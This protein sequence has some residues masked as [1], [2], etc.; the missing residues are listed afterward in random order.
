MSTANSSSEHR[1]TYIINAESTAEMNRL[2]LQDRMLTQQMGGLFPEI[3]DV[4]HVHDVLDIACGPGQWVLDMSKAY[5]HMKVVGIDLSEK[6]IT[7]ANSRK[8]SRTTFH[9]MNVLQPLSLGG[10]ASIESKVPK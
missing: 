4:S 7:Y 9:V 8:L 3:V 10:K 5:P 2:T 1:S 6:M